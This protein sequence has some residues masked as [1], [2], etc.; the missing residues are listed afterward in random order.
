MMPYLLCRIICFASSGPED[1]VAAWLTHQ[2]SIAGNETKS[3]MSRGAAEPKLTAADAIID[4]LTIAIFMFQIVVVLVLGYFGNAWKYTQ[5]LKVL[6]FLIIS[7]LMQKI[8]CNL[9][10]CCCTLSTL[11][12]TCYCIL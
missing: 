3:G 4:K 6:I 5:G 9:H 8:H 12:G 7:V 10:A 1:I 11:M 2:S